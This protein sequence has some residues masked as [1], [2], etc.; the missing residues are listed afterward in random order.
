M[1]VASL[2]TTGSTGLY[3]SQ[4]E[5]S[6]MMHG[7][8]ALRA[9][10]KQNITDLKSAM[11]AMGELLGQLSESH[12]ANPNMSK[13]QWGK[14]LNSELQT[15][16]DVAKDLIG[17]AQKTGTFSKV[18][19]DEFAKK[20]ALSVDAF[21]VAARN[22]AY[23]EDDP[24]LSLLNATKTVT[25]S[26]IDMLNCAEE[27]QHKPT[28]A[29]LVKL[30]EAE[31][32]FQDALGYLNAVRGGQIV[33]TATNDLLQE[34]G[35][36]VSVSIAK[37]HDEVLKMANNTSDPNKKALLL[38]SNKKLAKQAEIFSFNVNSLGSGVVIP[39]IRAQLVQVIQQTNQAN[40][41]VL[42]TAKQ[43]S[44]DPAEIN[45]LEILSQD[46]T[47]A[48]ATVQTASECAEP[49]LVTS[50][51]NLQTVSKEMSN[52]LEAMKA[53][54]GDRGAIIAQTRNV[55]TAV[56]KIVVGAK[57]L[58]NLCDPNTKASLIDAARQ[59]ADALSGF[60]QSAKASASNPQEVVLQQTLLL[61][62][63]NLDT[64]GTALLEESEKARALA[65]VRA[66]V[67]ESVAVTSA[68]IASAQIAALDITDPVAQNQLT[69][70]AHTANEAIN[71][72]LKDLA[73]SNKD[74]T[75]QDLMNKL[76]NS[77]QN[78]TIPTMD[79]VAVSKRV[80]P[81]VTDLEKKYD[82]KQNSDKCAESLQKLINLTKNLSQTGG[83]IDEAIEN[84]DATRAEL[85]T[86]QIVAQNGLLKAEQGQSREDALALLN[87]AMKQ[88]TNSNNQLSKNAQDNPKN[89]G[90]AAKD[91]S[92]ALV[93][94]GTAAR[95]VASATA[96]KQTQIKII[97]SA[98]NLTDTT[99][100]LIRAAKALSANRSDSHLNHSLLESAQKVA[101]AMANLLATS[102]GL[103][104]KDVDEA[105][106]SILLE[107]N[108]VGPVN[109]NKDLI[110]LQDE[111]SNSAK[112]L[113]A[114]VSQAV[115]MAKSNPKNLGL[116]AKITASTLP[117]LIETSNGLSA[118]S[119]PKEQEQ[120]NSTT[121]DIIQKTSILLNYAKATAADSSNAQTLS[122]SAKDVNE[123]LTRL[124]GS[125]GVG[126]N[127]DIDEALEI[128]LNAT[129]NLSTPLHGSANSLYVN[130][131]NLTSKVKFFASTSGELVIASRTPDQ[132]GPK[133][134]KSATSVNE[135]VEITRETLA[136]GKPAIPPTF[137][138]P[139]R[140][141]KEGVNSLIEASGDGSKVVQA[142]RIIAASTAKLITATKLEASKETNSIRQQALLKGAQSIANGTSAIAKAAKALQSQNS[143]AAE[144]LLKAGRDLTTVINDLLNLVTVE[145]KSGGG[146]KLTEENMKKLSDAVR[147]MASATSQLI[148]SANEFSV[149]PKDDGA[150]A[151]LSGASKILNDAIANVLKAVNSMTPGAQEIEEA[152][153]TIQNAVGEVD[154]ISISVTVGNFEKVNT[155]KTHQECQENLVDLAKE[156]ASNLS[157]VINSSR[158]E[159]GEELGKAGKKLAETVFPR[160][161]EGI[162]LT[163]STT[164][165]Q[166]VQ[167]K[168]L[169][170]SKDLIDSFLSLMY[171]SRTAALN[172]TPENHKEVAAK[173]KKSTETLG[174]L[175]SNLKSGVILL[176]D[177]DECLQ[178]LATAKQNIN[179]PP[180][181]SKPYVE[182]KD[183]L[184]DNSKSLAASLKKLVSTNKKDLFQLSSSAKEIANIVPA[185]LED[186]K[187][188]ASTTENVS[189][190]QTILKSALEF[191][192][193]SENIVLASKKVA[194]DPKNSQHQQTLSEAFHNVRQ[195]IT[196][197]LDQVKQGA[198]GEIMCDQAIQTILKVISDLDTATLFAAAAQLEPQ[199]LAISVS[200]TQKELLNS[201]K[202]TALVT[203][204][205]VKSVDG[206]QEQFGKS[207]NNLATVLSKVSEDTKENASRLSTSR[208]QQGL[209]A[210]TKAIALASQQLIITGKEAQRFKTDQSLQKN[211]SK[212]AEVVAS[213]IQELI[214]LTQE[215]ESESVQGIESLMASRATINELLKDF[216]NMKVSD[217]T[218]D[219]IVKAARKI[220]ASSANLAQSIGTQDQ[221]I[222]ACE[223]ASESCK[224]LLEKTKG[225]SHLSDDPNIQK[226]VNTKA[227]KIVSTMSA[228]MEAIKDQTKT[229][230]AQGEISK[231][232]LNVADG[233]SELIESARKLPGGGGLKFEE[234]TG[235]DLESLASDELNSAVRSI[236]EATAAL[237][238]AKPAPKP[239]GS[240]IEFDTSDITT[241]I[242]DAAIA[243]SKATAKLVE[244][245]AHAQSERLGN[246]KK[247]PHVYRK[248]PMWANGLIS[249]AKSVAGATQQLV[250]S[251]NAS[252]NGTAQEEELVA[253]A[254]AVA[255]ATAQ[256]VTASRV[257]AD[258]NSANQKI[259]SDAAKTVV[260]A[261]SA[262][263]TAAK[264]ASQQL[265]EE[266]SD[267]LAS[268]Y[269]GNAVK[270]MEQQMKILKL[271]KELEKARKSML[272]SRKNEYAK[273]APQSKKK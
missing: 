146:E 242:F 161:V 144:A 229:G 265:E 154:S 151:Q 251:A 124:L 33:D 21:A 257:K 42:N 256:L 206:T 213:S 45:P 15:L 187:I 108:K 266:E 223:S 103:D 259:L 60:V 215:Q 85:E 267:E 112:A 175:V 220:A 211:V 4:E 19:L 134:K 83:D 196:N 231:N 139:A 20:I 9:S 31:K 160:L 43:T 164:T 133:A 56:N 200:D 91:S 135:I 218:P 55:A 101:S 87:L 47:T 104:S 137:A 176:R 238:A 237:L 253:V 53:S 165:D 86:A 228:L 40:K 248:D 2:S 119:G 59:C 202:Q 162:K 75:N 136:S 179:K 209:L 131:Q 191:G 225:A 81:K 169:S 184:T 90:K 109:T 122:K 96:D 219:A 243:I 261:T 234:D 150:Q 79:L 216:E 264:S 94:V 268:S 142:A 115:Q 97:D 14:Q 5:N 158:I 78:T 22:A 263:V 143:G 18:Q 270:H 149:K 173:F 214:N 199:N 37:F 44:S 195:S 100:E 66:Q 141:V 8:K 166:E 46:V 250:K 204:Q 177:L 65:T 171:S 6:P 222:R 72:L 233:I 73:T 207:A 236:E 114:A 39:E 155:K 168:M 28:S 167:N 80:L 183:Q 57:N 258:P 76:I 140:Y 105:I 126:S 49:M 185:M 54:L 227:V 239:K 221:M 95:G 99:T 67:K 23:L 89:V 188:S 245:A 36:A 148:S 212:G 113:Q 25:D 24:N 208:Q 255:A 170:L 111:L 82:L 107:E 110:T 157:E 197:L 130:L 77:V 186:A 189:L 235:E 271:E 1:G 32:R 217:S 249:A 181:F 13:E 117:P 241:A 262:L 58:A 232:S 10:K 92:F 247:N 269:T 244:S 106:N 224:E 48:L 62:I 180:Q 254:R 125:L 26:V 178:M 16:T 226:E 61:A 74:P 116:A 38:E 64:T 52:G 132:I 127:P 145:A 240:K 153:E 11:S 252:A 27:V 203:Q 174:A 41:E 68:L 272:N 34:A 51:A 29:N 156:M 123:A 230:L 190:K 121:K 205:L 70:K 102:R 63:E 128:I 273:P 129:Q 17:S 147:G 201:A 120:L 159:S 172:S 198:V 182:A 7:S 118:I 50:S 12:K 3:V 163:I 88:L 30:R 69:G 35:K 84:I 93:Q 192:T 260:S 138:D 152:I 193:A 210:A 246:Q 71:H 194:E 98:K